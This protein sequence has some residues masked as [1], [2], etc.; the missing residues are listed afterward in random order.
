MIVSDRIIKPTVD[1]VRNSKSHGCYRMEL[2][3]K[4]IVYSIIY[5]LYIKIPYINKIYNYM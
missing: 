4:N 1:F 3:I 5:K 2:T